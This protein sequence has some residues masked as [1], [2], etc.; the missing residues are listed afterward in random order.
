MTKS[1][2]WKVRVKGNAVLMVLLIFRISSVQTS[3]SNGGYWYVNAMQVNFSASSE[4]VSFNPAFMELTP[5]GYSWHCYPSSNVSSLNATSSGSEYWTISFVNLQVCRF[6][7]L[8]HSGFM[9][10]KG[11]TYHSFPVEIEQN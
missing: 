5:V 11:C 3:G 6:I 10:F 2:S 4:P 1:D 8:F 7:S 9:L